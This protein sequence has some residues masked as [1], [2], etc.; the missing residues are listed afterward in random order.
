MSFKCD[1]AMGGANEPAADFFFF[2]GISVT[3]GAEYEV[4]VVEL[5]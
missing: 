4:E 2:S 1:V 5:F 3:T